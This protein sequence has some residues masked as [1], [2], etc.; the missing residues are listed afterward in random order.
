MFRIGKTESAKHLMRYLAYTDGDA[1]D[2]DT[3]P[4][5]EGKKVSIEKQVLDANPILESFGNAKTVLNNNSSRFGKFTKLVF[6][7]HE[8]KEMTDTSYCANPHRKGCPIIEARIVGSYIET[9]LLEKSRVV[10]QDLNERNY[11]IFYELCDGGLDPALFAKCKLAAPETFHYLNQSKCVTIDGASDVERLTELREAMVTLRFSPAEQD[12]V[13]TLVAGILHLGN[14]TFIGA[15]AGGPSRYT[16]TNTPSISY[17]FGY[18]I[19][20]LLI[21][22]I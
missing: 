16:L 11:H 18:L 14:I 10:Q 13:F 2:E 19:S 9:Y 4:R 1:P 3:G 6:T 21:G 12:D 20:M 22:F 8:V 17:T 7:Q 15:G 5:T